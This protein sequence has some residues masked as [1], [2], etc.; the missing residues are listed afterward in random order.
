MNTELIGVILFF[1]LTLLLAIPLGK[2]V[3]RV[4]LGE[5]TFLDGVMGPV[6]RFFFRLSGID[7]SK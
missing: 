4:Y 1:G 5:K 7:T 2:Y 6:E 3:A